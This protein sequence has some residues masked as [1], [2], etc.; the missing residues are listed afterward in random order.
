MKKLV[1]ISI[2]V[3]VLALV[4]ANTAQATT[5][6]YRIDMASSDPIMPNYA[7]SGNS[8]TLSTDTATTTLNSNFGSDG[9][10][11]WNAVRATGTYTVTSSDG[12]STASFTLGGTPSSIGNGQGSGDNVLRGGYIAYDGV[13]NAPFSINLGDSY[14]NTPVTL[15]MYLF[16]AGTYPVSTTWGSESGSQN[17]G[18]SNVLLLTSNANGSGVVNGFFNTT[19]ANGGVTMAGLQILTT[20]A[21]PEPST[22]MLL[23]VGGLSLISVAS[24]TRK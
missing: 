1:S 22:L 10:N 16:G 14:A 9:V 17:T 19:G 2:A 12:S 6:L 4:S 21:V 11:N 18:G 23:A 5:I 20:S 13:T 3:A 24:R 7:V 15:A 8:I